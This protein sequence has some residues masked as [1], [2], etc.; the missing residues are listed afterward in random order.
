M[1]D[2]AYEKAMSEIR[3]AKAENLK[4]LN[5]VTGRRDSVRDFGKKLGFASKIC[6]NRALHRRVIEVIGGMIRK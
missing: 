2:M 4:A 3:A 1:N 5:E 6:G